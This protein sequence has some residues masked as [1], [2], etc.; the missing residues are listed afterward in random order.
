MFLN[1]PLVEWIGYVASI[2]VA[3]SLT[4]SSIIK[5][6]WYNL[7][8]SAVF[9]FY[10]FAIG[11]LPVGL[12]NLFIVFVNIYYLISIY[13]RKE[14]FKIISIRH[15]NAYLKYFLDFYH[16]EIEQ[17]FPDF[18]NFKNSILEENENSLSLIILRNA[19]VAGIFIGQKNGDEVLVDLDFVIPEFRD[20]KP[21]NY[22]FSKNASCFTDQ[23]IS[24]IKSLAKNKKHFGYLKRMGFIEQESESKEKYLVKTL[25]NN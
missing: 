11:S 12:L 8:G 22:L 10:G 18:R 5:L 13:S 9:S 21:G 2:V 23:D 16:H 25:R 24:R 1:I 4:M 15:D 6:R 20:L 3:V 19:A 14:A 17:F 7:A